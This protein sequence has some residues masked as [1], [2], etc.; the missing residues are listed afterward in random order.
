MRN[1]QTVK[2]QAVAAAM[3]VRPVYARGV[4]PNSFFVATQTRGF[5]AS[6]IP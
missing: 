3:D 1:A 2:T 5:A 6:K 4:T